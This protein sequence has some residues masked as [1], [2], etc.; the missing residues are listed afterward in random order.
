MVGSTLGPYH[1]VHEVDVRHRN[2]RDLGG[3]LSAFV[4][5]HGTGEAALSVTRANDANGIEDFLSLNSG[6][7]EGAG[8]HAFRPFMRLAHGNRRQV[9]KRTLLGNCAAVR[10]HA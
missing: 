1:P 5:G 2:T 7:D 3:Y 6:H 10:K 8:V 9:E 4:V